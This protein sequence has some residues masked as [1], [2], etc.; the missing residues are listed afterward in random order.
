[1]TRCLDERALADVFAGGGYT[2][3]VA[4]LAACVA[5]R[6]RYR[7]LERD[8][9]IVRAALREPPPE[10]PY[11]REPQTERSDR[12]EW[13]PV[14]L[15]QTGRGERSPRA[16]AWLGTAAVAVAAAMAIV[17]VLRASGAPGRRHASGAPQR[18]ALAAHGRRAEMADA[19]DDVSAAL[20]ATGD[21]RSFALRRDV[22]DYLHATAALSGGWPCTDGLGLGSDCMSD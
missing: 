2:R 14:W 10:L 17:V 6:G 7:A 1:M 21:G 4:H 5:C 19:M 8:L 18:Y 9:A 22:P 3:E 20:F 13:G 11:R 12:G 16:T 15:C